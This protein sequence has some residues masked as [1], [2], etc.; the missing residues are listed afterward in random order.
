LIT[1]VLG[2]LW[3]GASWN[4]VIWGAYHGVLL[5]TY[6]RFAP[7]WDRLPAVVRQLSMFFFAVVGWVFFRATTL[8]MAT[9]LLGRMFTPV[10]GDLVPS[11]TLALPLVVIAA[12]WAMVGPNPFEMRL[13]RQW[14][15]RLVLTASFAASLALIL[16][17]RPSPFLYFQF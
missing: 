9:S 12:L 4:F 14:R 8:G 5:L 6:R 17:S 13:E 1:M 10:A 2:G 7:S 16:G 3:H 11:V 15:G